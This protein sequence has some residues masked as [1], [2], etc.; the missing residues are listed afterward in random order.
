MALL[1]IPVPTDVLVTRWEF[2]GIKAKTFALVNESAIVTRV[3]VQLAASVR[4]SRNFEPLAAVHHVTEC[5][6]ETQA[7]DDSYSVTELVQVLYVVGVE[8]VHAEWTSRRSL[9]SASLVSCCA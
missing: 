7:S 3:P 9:S 8:I 6:P 2:G 5:V 1:A 4:C